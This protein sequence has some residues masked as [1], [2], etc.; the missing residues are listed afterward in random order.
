MTAMRAEL[1]RLVDQIGEEAL[2]AAIE[3]LRELA[4]RRGTGRP[5]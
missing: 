3:L 4:A 1:H 2:P 5:S